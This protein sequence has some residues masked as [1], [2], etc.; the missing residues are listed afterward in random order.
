MLIPRRDLD[1]HLFDVLALD[2]VLRR[3]RFSEHD[4]PTIDAVLDAAYE[5]AAA[6]FAPHAAMT[7]V[8][9]PRLEHGKVVLPEETR[10]AL[11]AYA[12]GGFLAAAF[13]RPLGGLGLP[14]VVSQA[15]GGVFASASV[16][17]YSYAL[18]TQAAANV[19]AH[20]GTDAQ[21]S[22]YLGD[23]LQ[24][25]AFGTMCLSEPQAGSSLADLR[26]TA[27]ACGDGRYRIAGRKMWISGGE[28]ELSENIVHLVLARVPGGPAGVKGISLFIVI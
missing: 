27:T 23:M 1:F 3:P 28:H 26:T 15:C 25:R 4:R 24:G 11:D 18:L 16:A 2:E 6:Q 21:R 13:P 20:F 19:I 9:E 17:V 22:R 8:A 14:F 7:D 5:L 10:A 12:E